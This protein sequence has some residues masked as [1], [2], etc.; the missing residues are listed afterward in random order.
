MISLFARQTEQSIEEKFQ[1]F[2]KEND[3]KRKIFIVSEPTR[4][5][6]L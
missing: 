2:M 3:Q 1:T 5:L 6:V 4:T